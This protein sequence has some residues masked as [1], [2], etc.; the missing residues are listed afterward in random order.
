M[1][2]TRSILLD[3]DLDALFRKY[4]EWVHGSL[5]GYYSREVEN[6]MIVEMAWWRY[7]PLDELGYLKRIRPK[8]GGLFARPLGAKRILRVVK[9]DSTVDHTF[10]SFVLLTAGK[11]WGA[12]SSAVENG[13]A[14]LMLLNRFKEF[15]EALTRSRRVTRQGSILDGKSSD[16]RDFAP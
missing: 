5:W 1:R 3:R 14:I 16:P 8:S 2:V 6:A 15:E 11:L 10:K 13:M 9:V 4:V 12:Y 7:N